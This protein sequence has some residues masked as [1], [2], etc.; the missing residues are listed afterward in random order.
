MH[1]W[2]RRSTT[3]G[4]SGS[5]RQAQCPTEGKHTAARVQDCNSGDRHSQQLLWILHGS[6]ALPNQGHP[7]ATAVN[8][9]QRTWSQSTGGFSTK[10]TK[11]LHATMAATADDEVTA[12]AATHRLKLK[13][14]TYDGNYAAYEEWTYKFTAYMGLQDPFY[15][16]MFKAGRSSGT[17]SNRGTSTTSSYN[18]GR[19]RCMGPTRSKPEVPKPPRER[20]APPAG[21]RWSWQHHQRPP[22]QHGF[23]TRL[24]TMRSHATGLNWFWWVGGSTPFTKCNASQRDSS[25]CLA[26]GTRTHKCNWKL[27]GSSTCCQLRR[28]HRR[29]GTFSTVQGWTWVEQWVCSTHESQDGRG[30]S[31]CPSTSSRLPRQVPNISY[32]MQHA[33]AC[34]TQ[35]C[36]AWTQ[37]HQQQLRWWSNILAANIA[38][39]L[40]KLARYRSRTWA[41]TA[42]DNREDPWQQRHHNMGRCSRHW[43]YN[44]EIED[45]HRGNMDTDDEAN[46]DEG[47]HGVHHGWPN[48]GSTTGVKLQ[49]PWINGILNS[50]DE[51]NM[52]YLNWGSSSEGN[53][54]HLCR[55]NPAVIFSSTDV[56]YPGRQRLWSTFHFVKCAGVSTFSPFIFFLTQQL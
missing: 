13:S 34:N 38:W 15:P 1:R 26:V 52:D 40:V 35:D 37:C 41:T 5:R 44:N 2:S 6:G 53:S 19:S 56:R 42:R 43:L 9:R 11:H 32:G 17:T 28:Q 14:P 25:T 49:H 55:L 50:R 54:T 8:N 24:N 23:T 7:Q 4:S 20:Q 51:C 29:S 47:E 31:T 16:R 45:Y 21:T 39:W 3:F 33:S 12:L 36:S 30:P 48:T 27:A 10:H 22:W 46:S 18:T